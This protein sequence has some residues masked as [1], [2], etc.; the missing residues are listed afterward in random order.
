MHYF[1]TKIPILLSALVAALLFSSC[2][3]KPEQVEEV[4][5][6]QVGDRVISLDEFIKR[7]EYTIRPPYAKSNQY[8]TKKII[9][10]SLIAEKL[11][12]LEAGDDNAFARNKNFQNYIT[13]RKEQEMR[14]WLFRKEGVEKV[15]VSDDE[16]LNANRWVGRDY[17]VA[18]FTMRTK[19]A[20]DSAQ[21]LLNDPNNSFSDVYK[22]IGGRG[23]LP[24]HDISWQREGNDAV[25]E[26]IYSDSLKVGQI[27]GPIRAEDDV[28]TVMKVLGWNESIA[29]T[30][31]QIKLRWNDVKER[32]VRSDAEKIYAN[33]A[34][35]VMKGK[36]V[37]FNQDSFFKVA[38]IVKPFYV[39]T[40]KQKREAFN[41]QF[42]KEKNPEVDY[43]DMSNNFESIKDMPF[44]TIDG[45][46]WTVERLRDEINRH[47]LV[48]RKKNV[49][50]KNFPREFKL[51]VVDLIRD[52]YLTKAAYKRG[53]DKVNVVEE[54]TNMW[55]DQALAL[56]Q[57][58]QYLHSQNCP[59]N[60]NKNYMSVI[61]EYLN[62]YIDSLQTKYSSQIGINMAVFDAVELTRIDMF[63]VEK[64][65]PYPIAV[66]SFPILTTDNRLDYGR[67]LSKE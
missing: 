23:E 55:R 6:A 24:T 44:L 53:Y 45:E 49:T 59:Y 7:S 58:S 3:K 8:I 25:I 40:E 11:L 32:A 50:N 9:L 10:N 51:A 47:P 34:L 63:V 20:A 33:F 38:E 5:I 18:Y 31:E 61:N 52:K 19:S 12:A 60:F 64:N 4:V 14:K 56:W 22:K 41:A 29:I 28:Y 13:A 67:D 26:A 42:W 2:G 57:Q 15:D 39:K 16:L 1:K 21:A 37:E 46:T 54:Y 27:V 65:V 36:K 17:S 43:K 30:D 48:F 66:P 62:P 35:K